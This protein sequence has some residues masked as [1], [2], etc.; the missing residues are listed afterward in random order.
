MDEEIS[1]EDAK[2]AK[3]TLLKYVEQRID[4]YDP[5]PD[6]LPLKMARAECLVFIALSQDDFLD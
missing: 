6:V 4:S 5:D 3:E 2:A 1:Y